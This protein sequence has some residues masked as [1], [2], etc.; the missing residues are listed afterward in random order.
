MLGPHVLSE[1][2]QLVFGGSHLK[3]ARRCWVTWSTQDVHFEPAL[4]FVFSGY[5]L[6]EVANGQPLFSW[7]TKGR[8][9]NLHINK[10]PAISVSAAPGYDS[11]WVGAPVVSHVNGTPVLSL[12]FWHRT[13]QQG[14]RS[15]WCFEGAELGPFRGV[16]LGLSDFMNGHFRHLNWRYVLYNMRIHDAYVRAM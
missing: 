7:Q 12:G 6:V 15:K 1:S 13:W 2:L 4:L 5:L 9:Y 8:C 10:L 3:R 16:G 14:R 11:G